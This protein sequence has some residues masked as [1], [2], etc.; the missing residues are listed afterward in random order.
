MQVMNLLKNNRILKR[1]LALLLSVMVL[2]S[3]VDVLMVSVMAQDVYNG[4]AYTVTTNAVNFDNSAGNV[5]YTVQRKK[6]VYSYSEENGVIKKTVSGCTDVYEN[7]YIMPL[8]GSNGEQMLDGDNK[9]VYK[10]KDDA[11]EF[12]ISHID[13]KT[14]D[15]TPPFTS[16]EC[17]V[18]NSNY[19]TDKKHII[20]KK[21]DGTWG[22][23]KIV[24]MT[25]VEYTVTVTV[26]VQQTDENGAPVF[27]EN[28]E[29]VM[30]E[31]E[32]QQTVTRNVWE[33]TDEVPR[34][35]YAS[36]N[37]VI[38]S[39]SEHTRITQTVRIA[40]E[41]PIK[42]TLEKR[43]SGNDALLFMDMGEDIPDACGAYVYERNSKELSFD[44]GAE[45]T[46]E[47]TVQARVY[48]T[49]NFQKKWQ[50]NGLTKPGKDVFIGV[51][52]N[53]NGVEKILIP[54][55]QTRNN[56]GTVNTINN[57]YEDAEFQ[58]SSET[59]TVWH[60]TMN[61]NYIYNSDGTPRTFYLYEDNLPDDYIQVRDGN[62]IKNIK[63]EQYEAT[64]MWNDAE[65]KYG[66]RPEPATLAD[67]VKD[68]VY[69]KS[70]TT[71]PE[72]KID[73][74]VVLYKEAYKPLKQRVPLAQYS[75]DI[76]DSLY[77]DGSSLSTYNTWLAG[78]RENVDSY[79]NTSADNTYIN[80]ANNSH[81]LTPE[82]NTFKETPPRMSAYTDMVKYN[83]AVAEYNALVMQ[84]NLEV[85]AYNAE[86]SK[87]NDGY[88]DTNG[89]VHKGVA[90]WNADV[91]NS[92]NGEYRNEE[93][94]VVIEPN[95]DNTWT[96]KMPHAM[97]CDEQNKEYSYYI[98]NAP[99]LT[100]NLINPNTYDSDGIDL[101]NDQYS[102]EIVNVGNNALLTD[103]L[104]TGG[105]ITD[106]LK[107]STELHVYKYWGDN[108]TEERPDCEF[109]IYH[110]ADGGNHIN[111]TA[112]SQNDL[113]YA[114]DTHTNNKGRAESMMEYV[115]GAFGGTASQS[116]TQE[117]TNA[118]ASSP[119]TYYNYRIPVKYMPKF[120]PTGHIYIYYAVES[121]V[122]SFGDS[123][124]IN[125]DTTYENS[126]YKTVNDNLPSN[127]A[128]NGDMLRNVLSNST[129]KTVTKTWKA[130]S[131]QDKS[132]EATFMI[133]Q[134]SYVLDSNKDYVKE[135]FTNKSTIYDT[136]EYKKMYILYERAKENPSDQNYKYKIQVNWS[137]RNINYTDYALYNMSDLIYDETHKKIYVT[138]YEYT[139]KSGNNVVV[140]VTP[141]TAGSSSYNYTITV[142]D[143]D[144]NPA[145]DDNNNPL[146]TSYT[147]NSPIS[148]SFSERY[149]DDIY[150][151]DNDGNLTLDSNGKPILL[152]STDEI[153]R[154][155][156]Y[157][158]GVLGFKDNT[159]RILK[160]TKKKETKYFLYQY[161]TDSEN[162]S[163]YV[164]NYG[165]NEIIRP[166]N[167][168]YNID[169]VNGTAT[170][171][172]KEYVVDEDKNNELLSAARAQ[173]IQKWKT[174]HNYNYTSEEELDNE[175]T[176]LENEI[177]SLG[178]A[179]TGLNRS[180]LEQQ[181]DALVAMSEA[182]RAYNLAVSQA[183]RQAELNSKTDR[184]TAE[185]E[186]LA[187]LN[188][189]L[190]PDADTYVQN[191]LTV[192]NNAKT[193]VQILGIN[194]DDS[195]LQN[196]TNTILKQIEL[197][198]KQQ[199]RSDYTAAA[200][201]VNEKEF[202]DYID[203]EITVSDGN[204]GTTNITIAEQYKWQAVEIPVKLVYREADYIY[205][206]D[207]TKPTPTPKEPKTLRSG[208]DTNADKLVVWL[209]NNTSEQTSVTYLDWNNVQKQKYVAN[210]GYTGTT[211]NY[212]KSVEEETPYTEKVLKGF[213]ETIKTKTE[214]IG[215]PKYDSDGYE[216][217]YKVYEDQVKT[218]DDANF[219]AVQE[220]TDETGTYR[221]ITTDKGYQYESREVIENGSS[222]VVNTLIGDV[223]ANTTKKFSGYFLEQISP[224]PAEPTR[225][226]TDSDGVL[227]KYYEAVP[228]EMDILRQGGNPNDSIQRP[229]A[230]DYVIEH[231]FYR[232]GTYLGKA[233]MFVK[234]SDTQSSLVYKT[235]DDNNII[236]EDNLPI[237]VYIETPKY[238]YRTVVQNGNNVT[239]KIIRDADKH[240]IERDETGVVTVYNYNGETTP[241]PNP[242]PVLYTISQD[243]STGTV[244]ITY[245]ADTENPDGYTETVEKVGN[246][247]IWKD[248]DGNQKGGPYANGATVISI[249]E[250]DEN[251]NI[252]LGSG[253]P[254]VEYYVHKR[255]I[256]WICQFEPLVNYYSETNSG[257]NNAGYYVNVSKANFV[258]SDYFRDEYNNLK[259]IT[260]NGVKKIVLP[261]YNENGAEYI[262]D[263]LEGGMYYIDNNSF[264]V[265]ANT[266]KITFNYTLVQQTD[267]NGNPVM[268]KKIFECD[269]VGETMVFDRYEVGDG[270]GAEKAYAVLS[271]RVTNTTGRGDRQK[272]ALNIYKE[273]R[274]EDQVIYRHD[275]V[276]S[277]EYCEEVVDGVAK[278]VPV[279]SNNDE[280]GVLNG[281][282]IT[283]PASDRY[284]RY[285]FIKES[286]NS[287]NEILDDDYEGENT[288]TSYYVGAL[289]PGNHQ[290]PDERGHGIDYI[291][292]G[293]ESELLID[294]YSKWLYH[295]GKKE[296]H[297][298][299]IPSEKAEITSI[300]GS[301]NANTTYYYNKDYIEGSTEQEH[302]KYTTDSSKAANEDRAYYK[303]GDKKQNFR[304]VE[305][306]VKDSHGNREVQ[307][308]QRFF[309]NNLLLYLK[310]NKQNIFNIIGQH[311][312]DD[313]SVNTFYTNNN[314]VAKMEETL[315]EF[316]NTHD[317]NSILNWIKNHFGE[318]QGVTLSKTYP[319][320][321]SL[322]KAI[323][324]NYLGTLGTEGYT[325]G[326]TA[327][328]LAYYAEN[329]HTEKPSNVD[330]VDGLDETAFE[331][332]VQTYLDY[333]L[334]KFC[335][336]H[337]E[338]HRGN[339]FVVT[340]EQNYD[341]NYLAEINYDVEDELPQNRPFK[342]ATFNTRVGAQEM[343]ITKRWSD[344]ENEAGVRPDAVEYTLTASYPVFADFTDE[345]MTEMKMH[346]VQQI[347]QDTHGNF[348]KVFSDSNGTLYYQ[349]ALENY[350]TKS[351]DDYNP[352]HAPSVTL[353]K[354]YDNTKATIL[355]EATDEH[356]KA[357]EWKY[358]EKNYLPK[359]TF[360][361]PSDRADEPAYNAM[362]YGS[363][364][365]GTAISYTLAETGY[366]AKIGDE[367]QPWY[368]SKTVYAHG[369]G[370]DRTNPDIPNPVIGAH[371][372]GDEY[373]YLFTGSV[374]GTA[375]LVV[376][377][378]WMDADKSA[379]AGVRPDITTVI[380]KSYIV[381]G[382]D[383]ETKNV[384]VDKIGELPKTWEGQGTED[385][386]WWK[387]QYGSMPKYT[388]QGYVINYYVEEVITTQTTGT[389]E[390]DYQN[391]ETFIGQPTTLYVDYDGNKYYTVNYDQ[392][393]TV[394]INGDTKDIKYYKSVVINGI[395]YEVTDN[396][397][398]VN[399]VEC[400]VQTDNDAEYIVY[401]AVN[402]KRYYLQKS[403]NRRIIDIDGVDYTVYDNNGYKIKYKNTEYPVSFYIY[404]GNGNEI[405]VSVSGKVVYIGAS[406]YRANDNDVIR[407]NKANWQLGGRVTI[408]GKTY[409]LVKPTR[410]YVELNDPN[411][412]ASVIDGIVYIAENDTVNVNGTD[413]T[414]QT[415]AQNDNA[416][417]IVY[418]QTE[419]GKWYYLQDTNNMR[420]V[421]VDGKDYLVNDSNRIIKDKV[422]YAV[423]YYIVVNGNSKS[424]T[425]SGRKVK[426]DGVEY[427][428]DYD[429]N[430]IYDGQTCRLQGKVTSLAGSSLSKLT[431]KYSSLQISSQKY[432]V[433]DS[434]DKSI[435]GHDDHSDIVNYET[436]TI[437]KFWVI[438]PTENGDVPVPLKADG[439]SDNVK[440]N[441]TEVPQG[442]VKVA[443]F[444]FD[445][446]KGNY[447]QGTI[448][449]RP[450]FQRDLKGQ[451]V[452]EPENLPRFNLGAYDVKK[453]PDL[454]MTIYRYSYNEIKAMQEHDDAI[455][456]DSSLS[457]DEK[458]ANK[459]LKPVAHEQN[460][461]DRK[462][463][464]VVDSSHIVKMSDVRS[465]ENGD[466]VPNQTYKIKVNYG[467]DNS[468]ELKTISDISKALSSKLV[469][470]DEETF[471]WDFDFNK[472]NVDKFDTRG[473]PYTYV[474]Q[475][476]YTTNVEVWSYL[477]SEKDNV[478]RQDR[479]E[480]VY[481]IDGI[482]NHNGTVTVNSGVSERYV[483][484]DGE[485]IDAVNN[486]VTIDGVKHS[487]NGGNV[488]MNQKYAVEDGHIIV[489]GKTINVEN[490]SSVTVNG[491]TF[492]VAE[493][494]TVTID[495]LTLHERTGDNRLREYYVKL[496][497]GTDT[498][499][500]GYTFAYNLSQSD[501]GLSVT[502]LYNMDQSLSIKLK[503]AWTGLPLNLDKSEYP[504]TTFK[505]VRS[506]QDSR[507]N[508]IPNTEEDVM[509]KEADFHMQEYLNI[510][511]VKLFLEN[512][513]EVEINNYKKPYLV[514]LDGTYLEYNEDTEVH[515]DNK[516]PYGYVTIGGVKCE[517]TDE[518]ETF[519]GD[520]I[521]K[522]VDINGTKYIH[523][524]VRASETK[525]YVVIDGV[526]VYSTTDDF[527]IKDKFY[528]VSHGENDAR[529]LKY[530]D[531]TKVKTKT[532]TV[533]ENNKITVNGKEYNVLGD[534]DKY[535]IMGNDKYYLTPAG[536]NQY[537]AEYISI[538]S[539]S[540]EKE[541]Y[542]L[543]DS[544]GK[545]YIKTGNENYLIVS[546][547]GNEYVHID[548]REMKSGSYVSWNY[549]NYS[550]CDR[551][552]EYYARIGTEYYELTVNGEER[553]IEIPVD[554]GGATVTVNGV[555]YAV[556]NGKIVISDKEITVTD[557]KAKLPV[558]SSSGYKYNYETDAQ[559]NI[560]SVEVIYT[561]E[562]ESEIELRWN[563][564]PY[565]APNIYPYIYNIKELGVTSGFSVS[566]LSDRDD[567]GYENNINGLSHDMSGNESADSVEGMEKNDYD[568]QIF[569]SAD[570][571]KDK[572][573]VN[574]GLSNN[575]EGDTGSVKI[576][577]LWKGDTEYNISPRPENL[578]V[579]LYRTFYDTFITIGD[580]VYPVERHQ[581]V[582]LTDKNNV[583][584]KFYV[585]SEDDAQNTNILDYYVDVTDEGDYKFSYTDSSGN[586]KTDLVHLAGKYY[587]QEGKIT[588]VRYVD[589]ANQRYHLQKDDDGYYILY[590][591]EKCR[592]IN[593]IIH[594]EQDIVSPKSETVDVKNTDQYIKIGNHK[595]VV[596]EG[597]IVYDNDTRV[598]GGTANTDGTSEGGNI[599][600]DGTTYNV[601]TKY[602]TVYDN[603]TYDVTYDSTSDKS[604]VII[605]GKEYTSNDDYGSGWIIVG[606]AN[607][608]V[609]KSEY[610]E[611][612]GKKYDVVTTDI[613]RFGVTPDPYYVV[614]D[615]T[616]YDVLKDANNKMYIEIDGD[617][618]Y[619][620]GKGS[621][622]GSGTQYYA[623]VRHVDF[624]VLKSPQNRTDENSS[625]RYVTAHEADTNEDIQVYNDGLTN[626]NTYS[627]IAFDDE[628]LSA[629]G[630]LPEKTQTFELVGTYTG[631]EWTANEIK[632]LPI[633]SPNGRKY[634][635][636][637]VEEK[638][639]DGYTQ[640]ISSEPV[641]AVKSGERNV[642]KIENTLVPTEATAKKEWVDDSQTHEKW[643]PDAMLFASKLSGIAQTIKYR[644]AYSTTDF[645]SG[646]N[647]DY[648]NAE[649]SDWAWVTGDCVEIDGRMY[650]A[651]T[652]NNKQYIRIISD[653]LA[654]QDQEDEYLYYAKPD[655]DGEEVEFVYAPEWDY[656]INPVINGVMYDITPKSY[657]KVEQDI[658]VKTAVINGK[659]KKYIEFTADGVKYKYDVTESNDEQKVSINN[660]DYPVHEVRYVTMSYDVDIQRV[661][662]QD[663]AVFTVDGTAYKYPVSSNKVTIDGVNYPVQ[664]KMINN[665]S[666]KYIVF[667]H[668]TPVKTEG[669]GENAKKYVEVR[670]DGVLTKRYLDE[671]NTVKMEDYAYM[672]KTRE[673]ITYT[674]DIS[675]DNVV[676]TNNTDIKVGYTSWGSIKVENAT[677]PIN[678]QMYV[679]TL[680]DVEVREE[681]GQ[682]YITYSDNGEYK[683]Y[684]LNS[685]LERTMELTQEFDNNGNVIGG[686][687]PDINWNKELGDSLPTYIMVEE[688]ENGETVKKL[689]KVR[690]MP[691]E[692]S[693]AYAKT[694]YQDGSL[695][696][697]EYNRVTSDSSVNNDNDIL[698]SL[699][700]VNETSNPDKEKDNFSM[701][702]VSGST[703]LQ[704]DGINV[705]HT[706]NT[707]GRKKITIIKDW[708]DDYNR[709]DNRG[710]FT[711][712]FRIIRQ[713]INYVGDTQEVVVTLSEDDAYK[714]NENGTEKTN[715]NIWIKSYYVPVTSN[716]DKDIL[717]VYTIEELGPAN[718]LY[719]D[720]FNSYNHF[721]NTDVY[722]ESGNDAT[723]VQHIE[724]N[725]KGKKADVGSL[726]KDGKTTLKETNE[727]LD[728]VDRYAA[729]KNTK[730]RMEFTLTPSKL[731]YNVNGEMYPE[732]E[733][734]F[735]LT[736]DTTA[737]N[738][739]K[740]KI[741]KFKL[742]RQTV[743]AGTQPNAD[744]WAY[745]TSVSYLEYV[746]NASGNLSA[747]GEG[748]WKD[749]PKH[750]SGD[751]SKNY[752][753]AVETVI[754]DNVTETA[755]GSFYVT[756]ENGDTAQLVKQGD[757]WRLKIPD[758][759]DKDSNRKHTVKVNAPSADSNDYMTVSY[760]NI[761]YYVTDGNGNYVKVKTVDGEDSYYINT[762]S[763]MGTTDTEHIY[764]SGTDTAKVMPEW[765]K[766]IFFPDGNP[767]NLRIRFKLQYQISDDDN[768]DNSKWKYVTDENSEY[769]NAQDDLAGIEPYLEFT[770]NENGEISPVRNESWDNLPKHYYT[771]DVK[772]HQNYLY[773]VQEVIVRGL[774][775][776]E[777]SSMYINLDS[778]DLRNRTDL[779]NYGGTW[780]ITFTDTEGNE[781][782][783]NVELRYNGD[784]VYITHDGK[785]YYVK[786]E[787][788]GKY[789]YVTEKTVDGQK[790]YYIVT[791]QESVIPKES[792][793]V[794]DDLYINTGNSETPIYKQLTVNNNK[795]YVDGEEV[796]YD[797]VNGFLRVHYNDNYYHA[798][799][800]VTNGSTDK[801]Y[802]VFARNGE[803]YVITDDGDIIAE[804]EFGTRYQIVYGKS[805]INGDKVDGVIIPNA[806]GTS[807]KYYVSRTVKI[808]DNYY[809]VKKRMY[810]MD[811]EKKVEIDF[812]NGTYKVNNTE[813]EI[814]EGMVTVGDNEYQVQYD[815]YIVYNN[816]KVDVKNEVVTINDE[817]YH[818]TSE[819]VVTIDRDYEVKSIKYYVDDSGEKREV[820][821]DENGYYTTINSTIVPLEVSN[822]LVEVGS[823]IYHLE[824]E[825]YITYNGENYTVQSFEEIQ[826]QNTVNKARASVEKTW[827]DEENKYSAR[828]YS[829]MYE[830]Q[831]RPQDKSEEWQNVDEGWLFD[832]YKE[833]I[834]DSNKLSAI[835]YQTVADGKP[836][837]RFDGEK[838]Y[839]RKDI[840]RKYIVIDGEKFYIGTN[841]KITLDGTECSYT[842]GD[843]ITVNKEYNVQKTLDDEREY[844]LVNGHRIY[845]DSDKVTIDGKE[846][847]VS[848]G[849]IKIT[850]LPVHSTTRKYVEIDGAK[851]YVEKQAETPQTYI[852]IGET[853]YAYNGTDEKLTINEKFNVSPSDNSINFGGSVLYVENGKVAVN[854]K[855]TFNV[856]E[857]K[858]T[859]DKLTVKTEMFTADV[860]YDGSN[861]YYMLD[862]VKTNVTDGMYIQ[863][864]ATEP[865]A[866]VTRD[867][868]NKV[869]VTKDE[870]SLK[871]SVTGETQPRKAVNAPEKVYI[872]VNVSDDENRQV[873]KILIDK[874]PSTDSNNRTLEYRFTESYLYYRG[875]TTAEDVYV[876]M[877]SEN[878]L[879]EKS[880][881]TSRNE[882]GDYPSDDTTVQNNMKTVS[883][884]VKKTWGEDLY[885]I[886][887]NVASVQFEIQRRVKDGA[888]YTEWETVEKRDGENTLTG[889]DI[890]VTWTAS[891]TVVQGKAS[892]YNGNTGW[893]GLPKYDEKNREYE[894]RAVEKSVTPTG[895]NVG[896]V[897]V[898]SNDNGT[899]GTVGGFS[900]TSYHDRSRNDDGDVTKYNSTLTNTPV[901][902]K[903][904]VTKEWQDDYDR[905]NPRESITLEIKATV[906]GEP[907]NIVIPENQRVIN[908]TNYY[909]EGKLASLSKQTAAD[910]EALTENPTAYGFYPDSYYYVWY[911]LP[912]CDEQGR[913]ILYT[914]SE[915]KTSLYDTQVRVT[916]Y[917]VAD[918]NNSTTADGKYTYILND[919]KTAINADDNSRLYIVK[920]GK[921]ID[922]TLSGNT[923]TVNGQANLPVS[924][925]NDK[926]YV[927][928]DEVTYEIMSGHKQMYIVVDNNGNDEKVEVVI[929]NGE[930]AVEG[931][932]T[933]ES[934]IANMNMYMRK[935]GKRYF[936]YTDV[937][938]AKKY[939]E[940]GGEKVEVNNNT[941]TIDGHGYTPVNDV[942]TLNKDYTV[943]TDDETG[944]RYITVN[945]KSIAVYKD[946][947]NNE[948]VKINGQRFDV[949]SGEGDTKKVTIDKLDLKSTDY[950]NVS[951]VIE[952]KDRDE[953]NGRVYASTYLR[954]FETSPHF[955][956][957]NF[958]GANVNK[959]LVYEKGDFEESPV[960]HVTNEYEQLG[961][962]TKIDFRD[963]YTPRTVAIQAAKHW[964]GDSE[965]N[966]QVWKTS[967]P[968]QGVKYTIQYRRFG[969]DT[970]YNIPFQESEISN[971]N[972]AWRNV[973]SELNGTQYKAVNTVGETNLTD[974]ENPVYPESWDLIWENLPVYEKYMVG[975]KFEYRVVE[976]GIDYTNPTKDGLYNYVTSYGNVMNNG[977]TAEPT[978]LRLDDMSEENATLTEEI[979]NKLRT[980]FVK[981]VIDPDYIGEARPELYNKMFDFTIEIRDM[982]N[983]P[984]PALA[985]QVIRVNGDME[986]VTLTES[987]T[988]AFVRLKHGDEVSVY[989]IPDS[990]MTYRVEEADYRSE[991]FTAYISVDDGTET[992]ARV[993]QGRFDGDEK[994]S[995]LYTN[996]PLSMPATGGS[997]IQIFIEISFAFITMGA[998]LGLMYWLAKRKQLD[999]QLN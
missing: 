530:N 692:Y 186:E 269:K 597:H 294:V 620:F 228:N 798:Q 813:V 223:Y 46:A 343:N 631:T 657:I 448:V 108:G 510:G 690:Y 274:D 997:G 887:M 39:Y 287:E 8:T 632:N 802:Y 985:V 2:I 990:G 424:V 820:H 141:K 422:S 326:N 261:R 769:E 590:N 332:L 68:L 930:L 97:K 943:K 224:Y 953:E 200:A 636:Y 847:A 401:P 640:T 92:I 705:S 209:D 582:E 266:G 762:S 387:F 316:L 840:E 129:G 941:L 890:T 688:T 819:K 436:D 399:S 962:V 737:K 995:I 391:T 749:L 285:K 775:E 214:G 535:F 377:K 982:N 758:R 933:Y 275:V 320:L 7:A 318:N 998:L 335:E 738:E 567:K 204:G 376:N 31:I 538:G 445:G 205:V 465:D 219:S 315:N 836:Y 797:I 464:K 206:L 680:A 263:I 165:G 885:N 472:Y 874:L 482:D 498:L 801:Y 678:K 544:N 666:V 685:Y 32:E 701:G 850:S 555:V 91:E 788:D 120:D 596:S 131:R 967:R 227:H 649:W 694:D 915:D 936:V 996:R 695:T 253:E 974:A 717:S 711:L 768:A 991:G 388:D 350:Y 36:N 909:E 54:A 56:D 412:S 160:C 895:T 233:N 603:K 463:P 513:R 925:E 700:T 765:A 743:N 833:S 720:D 706:T 708:G 466:S 829:V 243:S 145:V 140:D 880:E 75:D 222:I 246:E 126:P 828:P 340:D 384:K 718:T 959:A 961:N 857:G 661:N 251:G 972:D 837:F 301:Y 853:K 299:E 467:N 267:D 481:K 908:V 469:S 859:I 276:V 441:Q 282:S 848:G 937:P 166:W 638:V 268:I 84:Y 312:S 453:L 945:G 419:N 643:S 137:Y 247:I 162:H 851:Y 11:G 130:A 15:T 541:Y 371:H 658:P 213:S 354:V 40:S 707:V 968:P 60:Y 390:N 650:Y 551:D 488:I 748:S 241:E 159:V 578:K 862:G 767:E 490:S 783:E 310:N 187:E 668:D 6:P 634:Y 635:Y 278:W 136:G 755:V 484:I 151:R 955:N 914:I 169:T 977:G 373:T 677:Y 72:E 542:I 196:I 770:V 495:N 244:T 679:N 279:Y 823:K 143:P 952:Y 161:G 760:E 220:V 405:N 619:T 950:V 113:N 502:N 553:Y 605:N 565:Y 357:K 954:E 580:T 258:P 191:K 506:L 265:D 447:N 988:K 623:G 889:A 905:D 966:S 192:F 429:D 375:D 452:W 576:Q 669:S 348:Y 704:E 96:I 729:F 74:P 147:S 980:A 379:T 842:S 598:K 615:G 849:K 926:K 404:D 426:I 359:Y 644:M 670:I 547:N 958:D 533:G 473:N 791:G 281:N 687:F 935:N 435:D 101:Q 306:Y 358:T 470:E 392:K 194:P 420:V 724:F 725:E 355:L 10:I 662:N 647:P 616:K 719:L 372:T 492:E 324:K 471:S 103:A 563:N 459:L 271:E 109:A 750:P 226:E 667:E 494:N 764:P 438:K 863:A 349:D 772:V 784:Y 433:R 831:Y 35:S 430:I 485:Q 239:T 752:V 256:N 66:T 774:E 456:R 460:A 446:E 709:D 14:D 283:I 217:V 23:E 181:R 395:Y 252:V 374:T 58:I 843:S 676:F 896:A 317:D 255:K 124:A 736:P 989:N 846:F 89:V 534:T 879:Y 877:P 656:V 47:F 577:K 549:G 133:D 852:Q 272:E 834:S 368:N 242:L 232:N 496:V 732:S 211:K 86:I 341:V 182:G 786:G 556:E 98:K 314:T 407:Y 558:S 604:S 24:E 423:S 979:Y 12:A 76:T 158:N 548:V 839:V 621:G 866:N 44:D 394:D 146:S 336:A 4:S 810:Y 922:V 59:S 516:S 560:V 944:S 807:T 868:N 295:W 906:D 589:Y 325:G 486:K 883:L 912:V 414:V 689:K 539:A 509:Y 225:I 499:G 82:H 440:K 383:G 617:K 308:E 916:D 779:V 330:F 439:T 899:S 782:T 602:T 517:L 504:K 773:R 73:N 65:N 793:T 697:A 557:G 763:T 628:R 364:T 333:M 545:K 639:P 838:Y 777:V 515:Y 860:E 682:K 741:V 826:T 921:R 27:D 627:A 671:Y 618:Y 370:L 942:V 107:G 207:E 476:G 651:Y 381:L 280:Y 38:P 352:V 321:Q 601:Q 451:K 102:G 434:T 468:E 562:A 951:P 229:A 305:K 248:K 413:C 606:S 855:D 931:D 409:K 304:V 875:E 584:H 193:A 532:F 67:R 583:K 245:P 792:F 115:F 861:Y 49:Y 345:Q 257:W 425:V 969:T 53:D 537:T 121:V 625:D 734:T 501:N 400:T 346:R 894:Y 642:T 479:R 716:F 830:I 884:T 30:V 85:D 292:D 61:A 746:G 531:D 715:Q 369:G 216:F 478:N 727:P 286:Y 929:E 672:E 864:T 571:Q 612:G 984:I 740:D 503:K 898:E 901:V 712:D 903:L 389:G 48:S 418:P 815:E 63:T 185:D 927:T 897:N 999:K 78:H 521:Y 144:G 210:S 648:S 585:D 118:T 675:S 179:V 973:Y 761:I 659:K 81:N 139:D 183:E 117:T 491:Q 938:S 134:Y 566:S 198:D 543:K 408:A 795:L 780:K 442:Y 646:E 771:E 920:D 42:V 62:N 641:A 816:N 203:T 957:T 507:G 18:I 142:T 296:A 946:S 721:S 128:L 626:P 175:I 77:Q 114:L 804:N 457:D 398:T 888:G 22:E 322:L 550:V 380:Y 111:A 913:P 386:K 522:I 613:K 878:S 37:L 799:R 290:T 396:K 155:L 554:E 766:K 403:T 125:R 978:V 138:H 811:G 867:V 787:A 218:K 947:S 663:W 747:V 806:D 904:A 633:Y 171:I 665:A 135:D 41:T 508:E 754:V 981:K 824:Y 43:S 417:Y 291:D 714:Y 88:T 505:L 69:K 654:V 338:H 300:L 733:Q 614:Y 756:L 33:I 119:A 559:D 681:N 444:V 356:N 152:Y 360:A 609:T 351:G 150:A 965:H 132:D 796:E 347:V 785:D 684:F 443:P 652:K 427:T 881:T 573:T 237:P 808:G 449:N 458:E 825:N 739:Y 95:Y 923:A 455:D 497:E 416:K 818:V 366:Y 110:Y 57:H 189:T 221:I 910:A 994:H 353:S 524:D 13:I 519:V 112:L 344:G 397:V 759:I 572:T 483:E 753:Y 195:N 99:S 277:F 328:F 956:N 525:E 236:Y 948:Y 722:V 742:K 893:T 594:I 803:Y 660:T 789:N 971:A 123:Y 886:S 122:A 270:S 79:N 34:T 674:A 178:G 821:S 288:R 574:V 588:L 607:C 309:R 70:A 167:Y 745:D 127:Y 106:T 238:K 735:D 964:V 902:S 653:V 105:T 454:N 5:Q 212:P 731:W 645:I 104:Y 153:E 157:K 493:D 184:T 3:A 20:V 174:D 462:Y 744:S 664:T 51:K 514:S 624:P 148:A 415:D 201:A 730:E 361:Q 16:T 177:T 190:Q 790:K 540:S 911:K 487:C 173:E 928:I 231:N 293:V 172:D 25:T 940:I 587:V 100:D 622:D 800:K 523:I 993:A 170:T 382:D 474:L 841:N 723:D 699:N 71:N 776:K 872:K 703:T 475:E 307:H 273:Y 21:A 9:P 363:R 240:L 934:D 116:A 402:G 334:D 528:Y 593:S 450:V 599:T 55:E 891:D 362:H 591:G 431:N 527:T 197:L 264:S 149:V 570:T 569:L 428:A 28:N 511:D 865:S 992:K 728:A 907:A 870:S 45:N 410:K 319:D 94:I 845:V 188:E 329:N 918:G 19:G 284:I 313:N 480:F 164:L 80:T 230:Q 986:N 586:P 202:S 702:F 154:E 249:V 302:L 683:T 924:E 93:K 393:E 297:P 327:D 489:N 26:S 250:V 437:G 794:S 518:D 691:I 385:E 342:F 939:V 367:Y 215:V 50:S 610:V 673:Y 337:P 600:I 254:M 29:P 856:S 869:S 963:V 163:G 234:V 520:D 844:I 378:Y 858:V 1:S 873:P 323:A 180:V 812:S 854:D 814:D 568:T 64:V 696:T 411:Y 432:G 575:Y 983:N 289:V 726:D 546:E 949:V 421:T 552:D 751:V 199:L 331:K 932:S 581:Y 156:E 461:Y 629:Q 500:E 882:T 90:D 17:A 960:S 608:V 892:T 835:E 260:E 757:S 805:F 529:Y 693:L 477:K 809:T 406:G 87:H 526:N 698:N 827:S 713:N 579:K 83:Q 168:I 781:V 536:G 235:D 900:Y 919:T 512:R 637:I 592:L 611:I 778:T 975:V 876:P 208:Y 822:G 262:Y 987:N 917:G 970:W 176:A 259:E 303:S 52:Y 817:E 298:E 365:D 686:T 655:V 710:D 564:L 630:P 976:D 311:T 339:S 832:A 595:Y 871:I 561:G